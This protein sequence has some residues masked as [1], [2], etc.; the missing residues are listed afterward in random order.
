MLHPQPGSGVEGSA[1]RELLALRSHVD[2][3]RRAYLFCA[4]VLFVSSLFGLLVPW[5]IREAIDGISAPDGRERVV[6]A[7]SWMVLFAALHGGF[8]YLGR[9][10]MLVTARRV[11]MRLRRDVLSH[12][13]RLPLSFFQ[14][15]PTGDVMSRLTNDVSAVWLLLGPGVLTLVGTAI[16]YVLALLF[17]ARISVPLTLVSLALAPVIV[18]TS[19]QY[20][21][22]FHRHHRKAQE[23][24]SAMN[25]DLQ[26]NISGIRLVKAYGLEGR[27][28]GRFGRA[29]RDY[30]RQNVSVSKTSAAFHGAIGLLAGAGV[31][32]VLLLG[33]WLVIRGG[34]TLGG[35]V[36]FNA[37]LAM[38]SFPTMALGWVINLFQRGSSAMGRI[39]EFL[40]ILAEPHEPALFPQPKDDRA[41]FLEVRDLRFVYEGQERG[42]ALAG[43]TFSL[44]KGEIIG[45]VGK[46]GSGKSTLFSLLL[47]LHPVPPGTVFLAGRDITGISLDEVRRTVSLVSQDPFLFSDTIL[48]NI[49][50]G[51]EVPDET[52][53]RRAASM[54]RFLAEVEE[55]PE[56]LRTVIGERGISL[57]GGQKQRTTIARALCA[58]GELLLLDDALSAVDSETEREIF[59]EI[60]SERGGRTVLFSTH[61][62]AS[63]SRCD[64]ILVLEEGRVVEEGTHDELL[65]RGGAYF[66][67]YSRQMIVSE[68]EAAP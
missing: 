39:N 31:A 56:G 35:F 58:G 16:S 28:E 8:R 41:P 30:Y 5:M 29:C 21:R 26:E 22:A 50:F 49:G 24:L 47:R 11:E 7:V 62:M 14:R 48:A 40:E 3:H 32:L 33:G 36:A 17:M 15:T 12:V 20:G 19:R 1:I 45:L 9:R 52:E 34:L 63:L 54:A 60:L 44:R 55:M 6:R 61:R 53:A 13:I 10:G 42:E 38:L 64:R 65:S 23:S 68:L 67:L 37:Y 25:A 27:E 43:V 51:Q 46:T 4:L 59:R 66:D 57:S 18:Y 2:R